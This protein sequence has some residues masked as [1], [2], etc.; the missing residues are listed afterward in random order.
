[1]RPAYMTATR[2]ASS[3]TTPRSCVIQISAVSCW[4]QISCMR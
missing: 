1:M 2:S 4:R 3:A